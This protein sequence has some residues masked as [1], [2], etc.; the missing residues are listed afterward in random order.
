[1]PKQRRAGGAATRA[2]LLFT[3]E[4]AGA[5]DA[6]QICALGT[7]GLLELCAAD[8]AFHKH[9]ALFAPAER[10]LSRELQ[11]AEANAKLDRSLGAF[12]R[13]LSPHFLAGA[14]HKA[15]EFLIWRYGVHVHNVDAVARCAL[16]YHGTRW[17]AR[18]AQLLR[19]DG[20]AWAWVAPAGKRA[21]AAPLDRAAVV[22]RCQKDASLLR[23]LC[24]LGVEEDGDT[25]RGARRLA[26]STVV[27][28]ELLGGSG[29]GGGVP[30]PES[31]QEV[32]SHLSR[33]LSADAPRAAQQAGCM[34]VAQLGARLPLSPQIS[35]ALAE[36][37]CLCLVG[38]AAPTEA[39]CALA[40]LRRRRLLT[41]LPHWALASDGAPCSWLGPCAA[42]ADKADI[43]LLLPALV[44]R[45]A[46]VDTDAAGDGAAA[47]PAA[48]ALRFLRSA[49]LAGRPRLLPALLYELRAGGDAAAAEWFVTHGAPP[50]ATAAPLR[51]AGGA[52]PRLDHPSAAVR[53]L[54][55]QAMHELGA[56][57]TVAALA[58]A[59]GVGRAALLGCVRRRLSDCAP[60]AAA[61]VALPSLPSLLSAAGGGVRAELLALLRRPARG[62][63]ARRV[64]VDAADA[65]AAEGAPPLALLPPLIQQAVDAAD[66]AAAAAASA[67]DADGGADDAAARRRA[68]K[69]QRGGGANGGADDKSGAAV[70][71]LAR[72]SHPPTRWPSAV[73]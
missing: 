4:A 69:R 26:F 65:L 66:A 22:A 12:L 1:M 8:P 9:Q 35:I 59:A 34:L 21:A 27:V 73:C 5:M 52:P 29:G 33:V 72:S 3:P 64:V 31:L 15:L 45:L 25:P 62:A 6:P 56:D 51:A 14:A 38:G 40:V 48:D 47:A 20:G 19:L 61:I 32:V 37:V 70:R 46:S 18:V 53:L 17:F 23:A 55:V 7:N 28:L 57:A 67:D 71:A 42:L 30:K 11:T 16:P 63:L 36:R 39:L 49:R 54:A 68:A 60:V 58:K 44:A 41:K 13:A 50:P 10:Q 43:T 2:S 24:A